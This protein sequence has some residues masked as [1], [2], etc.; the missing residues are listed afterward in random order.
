MKLY[1]LSENTALNDGFSSEHGLSL[2]IEAGGHG[3][4]FDM[5]QGSLY[6][7]NAKKLGIDIEKVD[8]AIISHGHYDHGGGLSHF[9]KENKKASVYIKDGAFEN[10]YNGKGSYIGLE[11]S[12][13]DNDRIIYTS[14][15]AQITDCM[16]LYPAE[17]VSQDNFLG[18]FGLTR[19]INKEKLPDSFLHEQYLLIE[20]DGKRALISGCSHRGI[21]DIVKAF[22]PDILIGGFHT[23]KIEDEEKLFCIAKKLSEYNTLYYTCHC[24]GEAQFNVMK[25][26]LPS[27]HYIRAGQVIEI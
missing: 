26:I 22:S 7:E 18:N 9:L 12:F 19:E 21:I 6:S 10:Y 5:G 14:K 8:A 16:T 23:S 4:L 11:Q 3:I 13:R 25:K 27:L 24:T 17:A 1:V 15:A 20:E 2:Y